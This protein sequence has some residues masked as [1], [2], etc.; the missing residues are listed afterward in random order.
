MQADVRL[1]GGCV[2]CDSAVR[3]S[4]RRQNQPGRCSVGAT[5]NIMTA[6]VL[7]NGTMVIE[8]AAKEA[9]CGPGQLPQRHG[10]EG[11]RRGTDVIKI[12]GVRQLGG[13]SYSIIP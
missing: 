2:L 6:G 11:H 4:G 13:G 9:Y 10:R 12:R 5:M 7:A 8:N 3:R 1:V